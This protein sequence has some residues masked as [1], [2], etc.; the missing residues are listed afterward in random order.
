MPLY[1]HFIPTIFSTSSQ[2]GWQAGMPLLLAFSVIPGKRRLVL[3]LALPLARVSQMVTAPT[4]P[5]P[6][7]EI[8]SRLC[9]CPNT[10]GF[11]L[12]SGP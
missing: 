8:A 5:A 2:G 1:L 6:R 3:L 10:L 7:P 9:C 11:G 4:H 12:G